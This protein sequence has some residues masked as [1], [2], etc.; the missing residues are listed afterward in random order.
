[1]KTVKNCIL[2]ALAVSVALRATAADKVW[3]APPPINWNNGK[4]AEE[5]PDDFV[6]EIV[7]S[8]V[9]YAISMLASRSAVTITSN[10]AE[11]FA[12]RPWPLNK[13]R[14]F[15]LVRSEFGHGATGGYAVS[16]SADGKKVFVGHLSLG[17]PVAPTRSALLLQL[18]SVPSTIFASASFAR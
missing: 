2:V 13:G 10:Q 5:I 3:V 7:H 4:D 12:G 16:S 1:M 15:V 14:L 11:L 8:K 18:K 6:C 17:D 9:A